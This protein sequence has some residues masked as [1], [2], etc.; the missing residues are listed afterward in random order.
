MAGCGKL[1]ILKMENNRIGDRTFKEV[2]IIEVN[3]TEYNITHEQF[4]EGVTEATEMTKE[5]LSIFKKSYKKTKDPFCRIEIESYAESLTDL[6]RLLKA[7][8]LRVENGVEL[9]PIV[10]FTDGKALFGYRGKKDIEF[11]K[12]WFK[13]I[14][15]ENNN[16]KMTI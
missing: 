15:E 4:T 12:K 1:L 11:T 2:K 8:M 9:Q 5:A 7:Y 10:V 13:I 16:T 14:V 3:G 6:V